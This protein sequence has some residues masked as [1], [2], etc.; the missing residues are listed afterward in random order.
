MESF[1]DIQNK[2]LKICY[3]FG[4]HFSW[5]LTSQTCSIFTLNNT[6]FVD[7]H[8]LPFEENIQEIRLAVS[9]FFFKYI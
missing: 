1:E 8:V 5:N 2:S 4:I 6:N 7:F 9:V 3:N